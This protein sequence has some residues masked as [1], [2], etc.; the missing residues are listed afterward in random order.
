MD[1]LKNYRDEYKVLKTIFM[2]EKNVEGSSGS[3]V[4]NI[5]HV[6]YD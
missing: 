4:N 3:A 5:D 2:L 1:Y 6:S